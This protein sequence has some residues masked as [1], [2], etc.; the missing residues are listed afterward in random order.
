MFKKIVILSILIALALGI[1]SVRN[2]NQL[3]IIA[4][5]N[6]GP[7]SSL[8]STIEGIKNRL[9]DEGYIE[10]KNISYE[11]AD[12]GFQPSLIPQ[13][14]TSLAQRKP[15][16]MVV[17]TTPVAQY[18]KAKINDIPLVYSAITDPVEAA[19]L[20]NP[21]EADSKITGC[22][23]MQDISSMLKFT[24]SLLPGA[25]RVGLLY[26]PAESNDAALV[27]MMEKET[28]EH[29]LVLVTVPVEQS[30]DISM[31]MQEF[32]GK[33]DFIYVGV[34]GPIQPSLPA[35]AAEADKMNIPVINAEEKAV[36]EGI[37]LASFGVNYL[38]V[39]GNTGKIIT[40]ILHGEK[41][42]DISPVYLNANEH[43]AVVSI[44]RS[45]KLNLDLPE[46][47]IAVD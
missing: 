14:V 6:Y 33:V 20:T 43:K 12:V 23:D 7:H 8:E 44:N 13:M 41:V 37:I 25:R 18:A 47:V 34:S 24:K 5:A 26:S 30:R 40:R 19:L 4:I 38:E 2:K 1:F 29:D 3:P 42:S 39:G 16:V 45:K 46:K 35:I 17:L 22:S 28:K 32:K 21:N 15:K 27:K 9:R 36:K 31:R 11:I 10:N